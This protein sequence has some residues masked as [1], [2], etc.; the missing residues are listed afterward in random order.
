[1]FSRILSILP[2]LEYVSVYQASHGTEANTL[3]QSKLNY[4]IQQ[5][6]K[7]ITLYKITQD[8]TRLNSTLFALHRNRHPLSEK[9][10]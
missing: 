7:N 3:L 1:M 8:Y 6:S 2:S 4:K 9:N 5:S 10:I